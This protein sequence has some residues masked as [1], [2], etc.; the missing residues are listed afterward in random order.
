MRTDSTRISNEAQEAAKV[1]IAGE[2]GGEYVPA[3][4]NVYSSRKNAQDAHEAI[5]PTYIDK[6][7]ADLKD[8]LTTDQYKLYNLCLLYTS[9]KGGIACC[10][11]ASVNRKQMGRK[12]QQDFCAGSL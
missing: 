9:G 6:T 10:K 4:P 8:S 2:F 12:G 11:K 3:K 5:R 7:P 1:F